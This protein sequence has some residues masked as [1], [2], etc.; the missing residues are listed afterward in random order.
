MN[1]EF[2]TRFV[3]SQSKSSQLED[4][5]KSYNFVCDEVWNALQEEIE[6][7]T[8]FYWP[9]LEDKAYYNTIV[10]QILVQVCCA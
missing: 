6:S 5:L 4:I 2:K 3:T 10:T 7:G 8:E 1:V 9:G